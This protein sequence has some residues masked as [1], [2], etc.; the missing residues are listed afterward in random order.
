MLTKES[1]TGTG[2]PNINATLNSDGNSSANYRSH[3]LQGNGSSASAGQ[4]QASGYFCLVGNTATSNASYANMFGSMIIDILDYA[5]IN[6]NTTIR[7]LWGH[8][9]NGSGEIGI[10]SC[11]W[12]NTE[13]VTS[14]TF[15]IVGAT[16]F[17]SNSSFALYG[18]K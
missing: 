14:I 9:R 1:G 7:S 2:G 11:L 16:N 4:V 18:V 5:S 3:Y 10:D 17:V 12:L 13:A 6:K 8:D 15:S